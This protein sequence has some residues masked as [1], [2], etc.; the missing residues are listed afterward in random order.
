MA[1][2]PRAGPFRFRS[3]SVNMVVKQRGETLAR[4]EYVAAYE[5][6]EESVTPA[7]ALPCVAA[8]TR[9]EGSLRARVGRPG[10]G[11]APH[12]CERTLGGSIRRS[13]ADRARDRS[14]GRALDAVPRRVQTAV[15]SR[16]PPRASARTTEED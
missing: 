10:S 5:H 1:M 8:R 2:V 16:L 9:I 15:R 11:S 3:V 14:G 13:R 6:A 7:T 4:P 12:I